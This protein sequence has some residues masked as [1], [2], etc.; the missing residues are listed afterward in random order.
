[1]FI[2]LHCHS[3]YSFLRGVA[4][5][6]EIIAAAAEQKMPAVALTD[7]NGMYAAV[8]FYQAARKAGVKP[9]VGV[10]LDVA[11]RSDPAAIPRLRTP[12][13]SAP[14]APFGSAQG[15]RDDKPGQ[16]ATLVLLAAD[17]EGYSNL[18]QLVT[19]RHLGT[20]ELVQS[21]GSDEEDGRPVTLE[22][23][24]QH[25]IGV[26]ALAPVPTQLQDASSRS[27]TIYR[28]RSE[29]DAPSRTGTA[30]RAP[31]RKGQTNAKWREQELRGTNHES[32]VT[33]YFSRLKEIFGERLYIEVQ[34]L[35][36]RDGRRTTCTSCDRRS[37]CITV[38]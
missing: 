28:A 35:S 1:V 29:N 36:P 33:S 4:S 30:C 23:L 37:I 27:G 8:G 17:M 38:R 22:E 16:A 25:S 9:I 12:T 34:H 7:T 6:E 21:T 5:P 11:L 19:L 15:K 13:G 14:S 26:I 18:C 24:E 10:A 2:H 3:H 20:T 32:R 31:T